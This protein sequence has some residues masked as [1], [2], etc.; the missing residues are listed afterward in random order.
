MSFNKVIM[1]GHLC[2]DIEIKFATNTGKPY[3]RSS[4]AVNS[5]SG[6]GE[7]RREDVCFLDVVFFGRSA[8]IASEY[9][10]KGSHV[11]LDGRLAYETWQNQNGEN[12]YKH[13]MIVESL[14][15]L[16][17][18]KEVLENS[19]QMGQEQNSNTE[20]SKKQEVVSNPMAMPPVVAVAVDRNNAAYENKDNEYLQF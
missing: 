1:E 6:S 18:K 13:S 17:T 15:M 19:D 7:N 8:E 12:R 3:G 14:Q 9:C 11:L 20:F 16:D 4:I 2:R 5:V 10:H